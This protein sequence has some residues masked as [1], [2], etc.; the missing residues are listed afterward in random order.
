MLR[1]IFPV[2]VLVATACSKPEPP[3]VTPKEIAVRAV[4]AGGVALSLKVEVLNPNRF[5]MSAQRV[6]AVM[7][8]ASG[9]KVG[10][11]NYDKPFGLPSKTPVMLEVPMDV[12]WQSA[13]VATEFAKGQDVPFKVEGKVAMGGETFQVNV[14]YAVNGVITQA[15]I[16]D[17]ALKA[18]A[19]AA[20]ALMPLLLGL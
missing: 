5:G 7:T 12:P 10:E 8:L 19:G 11:I 4:G 20:G 17:A 1:A 9:S 6:T 16:R 13:L 14:P 18:G 15:Q 3:I 2:V